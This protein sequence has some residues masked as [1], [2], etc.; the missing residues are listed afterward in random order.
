MLDKIKSLYDDG[1]A[2]HLLKSRSKAPVKAG[3]TTGPREKW[4]QLVHDYKPGLNV[5]VRLGEASRMLDGTYLAVIDCD[6]KSSNPVDESEMLDAL[7]RAGVNFLSPRVMSGRGNGSRHVYVRVKEPAKT[8][9]IARSE[10]LCKVSMPGSPISKLSR[11]RLSQEKLDAGLRIRPAWEISFMCQ[12][13][14]VVLPPS[15]HPDTGKV[16]EWASANT[17]EFP[18]FTP[19]SGIEAPK[20]K[21]KELEFEFSEVASDLTGLDAEAV[22]LIENGSADNSASLFTVMRSMIK[23]GWG[24]DRILSILTDKEFSL[25]HV[26][27]AHAKTG[28]R[29]RAAFWL[30]KYTYQKAWSEFSCEA[31]FSN[32]PVIGNVLS[33]EAASAQLK[34][35]T[36]T[37]VHWQVL[38]ERND[39][40]RPKNTLKNVIMIL[41]N[42]AG[43][44]VFRHNLFS[45]RDVYGVTPPW[46]GEFGKEV[47][48]KDLTRIKVYL[49]H[50]FS[51]EPSTDKIAEAITHIGDKNRFHPVKDYLDPLSWDGVSRLNTWLK[52]YCKAEGPKEYL[53]A[54][55]RK[56]LCAMVARIYEPGCKFDTVPILQGR[57]GIRKSS[58]IEVL[59]A[60]W[61]TDA[62]INI[63]DKDSVM[64]LQGIWV[65]EL[66]ELAG[67]KR[68]DAEMLKAFIS[69]RTDR[70]RLP[71]GR[72]MRDFD[73]Q[74]ILMGTTNLSHY[75]TDETGNRRIWS[76]SVGICDTDA[77]RRDRDQ[78]FAEAKLAWELG[79][80]LWL[81]D[82]IAQEQARE[83]QEERMVQDLLAEKTEEFF[84]TLKD[85]PE[86][87]RRFPCDQFTMHEA[88]EANGPFSTLKDNQWEQQ[89]AGR[90]LRKIGFNLRQLKV[91]GRNKRLWV[92]EKPKGTNAVP[93]CPVIVPSRPVIRI[94]GN[95]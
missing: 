70:I 54:V 20:K 64:T 75:L 67:M 33:D 47:T 19:T 79:E 90:A 29:K 80:K 72:L 38:L 95:A 63:N 8:Y 91:E 28:D 49:A 35:L 43:S 42:A 4:A 40:G 57:Q 77:L 82:V 7:E 30:F 1:F 89:R 66:G 22:E 5:G 23:L 78:L 62:H 41:E 83:E 51:V 6:V 37:D 55:S 11:E 24:Q 68:A 71:Y 15:I 36:K 10:K 27:F 48:D 32:V 14:Q 46:G 81:D 53:E 93:S 45:V 59:S 31:D 25:G 13:Q 21:S 85:I 18:L 3:W 69:R 16:Y 73:R 84:R 39:Q 92:R 26:A 2:I 76:V 52:D 34:Q 17:G 88:F 74:G 56:T 65:V 50:R 44:N 58:A 94:S 12:G 9:L 87:D 60:P 61:Y 86:K